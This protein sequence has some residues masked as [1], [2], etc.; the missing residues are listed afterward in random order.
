VALSRLLARLCHAFLVLIRNAPLTLTSFHR[1]E[2]SLP[3]CS[4]PIIYA[5]MSHFIR[6]GLFHRLGGE[7][8]K[9]YSIF[10]LSDILWWH[11]LAE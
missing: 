4:R 7:K 6:I 8:P 3:R 11:H 9:F 10:K 1:L 5:Y 2:H